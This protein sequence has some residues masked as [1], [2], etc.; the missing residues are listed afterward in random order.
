[1]S[2]FF[3]LIFSVEEFIF[4]TQSKFYNFSDMNKKRKQYFPGTHVEAEKTRKSLMK[5]NPRVKFLAASK[6]NK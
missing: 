3:L 6:R 2:G 4:V 1:M 5:K